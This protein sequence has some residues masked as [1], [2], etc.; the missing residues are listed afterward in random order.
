MRTALAVALGV[1]AL[2]LPEVALG[3]GEPKH[4]YVSTV[5]RI[6]DG[7][8]I[9]AEASGDG[10]FRLTTPAGA[11][12]VVRGRD[13]EPYLRFADGAVYERRQ[14]PRPRWERVETGRT[15][16]WLDRR[17]S[18]TA[19]RPPAVVELEPNATHH[20]SDWRIEGTLDG[21]PFTIV[22]SLD[23]A[24]ADSG[25]GRQWLLVPVLAGILVYALVLTFRRRRPAAASA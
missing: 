14:G 21:R 16:T 18:W 5:E 4:G 6:V 20:I 24:T 7:R 22:G 9:E 17:T 3:H 10:H 11:T 23:W 8:G 13:G 15:H 2:A 25:I 1:A 19:A 12:V